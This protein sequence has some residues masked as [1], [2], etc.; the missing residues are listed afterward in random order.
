MTTIDVS[1]WMFL[2][3]PAQPGCPGQSPESRKTAVCVCV[4]VCV[5][6]CVEN[7]LSYQH[8]NWYTYDS[9]LGD[10]TVTKTITVTWLLQTLCYCYQC[11]TARRMTAQVSS[12]CRVYYV[13][14][15]AS[16]W[17]NGC[18]FRSLSY[19]LVLASMSFLL[20]TT[21]YN[22]V[23]VNRLWNGAPFTYLGT[24]SLHYIH[25]YT[26]IHTHT[27]NT[28]VLRLCGIC[29]GKPGWAGTRRN[30]HPLLSS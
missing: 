24:Q 19:I 28:T 1:G 9:R 7:S 27:H 22:V 2:L 20:V 16:V 25:T 18:T 12:C 13:L 30:I 3:V 11:G 21:L 29:P 17:C 15:L 4:H 5:C 26:Y 6:V 14:V 23:D 10:Q 8:Q